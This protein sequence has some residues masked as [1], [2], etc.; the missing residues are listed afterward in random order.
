MTLDLH[1][2]KTGPVVGDRSTFTLQVTDA[3]LAKVPQETPERTTNQSSM[4]HPLY[5]TPAMISH[6]EWAAR[7]HILPFLKPGEEAVGC[8]IHVRHLAPTPVGA[9]VRIDS[10]VSAIQGRRIT[11]H[12]TAWHQTISNHEILIGEGH[13]TQAVLNQAELY[14]QA[15]EGISGPIKQSSSPASSA[16][17]FSLELLDWE[18]P[19]P[20]TPYDE[21][22]VCKIEIND[23]KQA[24]QKLEGPYLLRFEIE[25]F[26]QALQDLASGKQTD[27]HSDF[28]ESAIVFQL[29]ATPQ[30]VA[31]TAKLN[32][33]PSARMIL[34]SSAIPDFCQ[35]LTH[36][37]DILQGKL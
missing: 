3:M 2:E 33:Q 19:F 28:L 15:Q 11:S 18:S 7:Q 12:A 9:T 1:T 5:G 32:D 25:G 22:I 10:V 30:G 35:Q 4:I 29:Q 23:G 8:E 13:I 6:M 21:W 26:L 16:C 36:R 14:R 24:P 37:L 20:C 34:S 31:L 27:Y 17:R